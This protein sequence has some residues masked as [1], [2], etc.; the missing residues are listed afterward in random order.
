MPVPPRN[1]QGSG[2]A[3]AQGLQ[4]TWGCSDPGRRL[5]TSAQTTAGDHDQR[6]ETMGCQRREKMGWGAI[7]VLYTIHLRHAL[8]HTFT[9]FCLYHTFKEKKQN[10]SCNV[11]STRHS[12]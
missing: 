8:Y 5:C 11:V 7:D 12:I 3:A 4:E 9:F 1:R 10:P 6:R 2:G